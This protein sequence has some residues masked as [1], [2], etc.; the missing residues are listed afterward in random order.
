MCGIM[1]YIGKEN[2]LP[3]IVDGLRRESY[4]GYDS[5]GVVVFDGGKTHYVKAVGKLEKLEEKLAGMQITGTVGLGHNRWATHGEVTELNAHPHTDCKQNIFVVH[6]GIIENY[7]VLKEALQ[8]KGHVFVSQ[9]DT[10]VLAHLIEEY[11]KGD[12]KQAVAEALLQVKGA[13]AIAVIAKQDPEKIVVARLSSPLVIAK[14]DSGV[15]VASDPA[16]IVSH[17]KNMVFLDDGEIAVIT[18]DSFLVTDAKNVAHEKTAT[19][20]AWN[21]EEIQKAGFAHFMQKEIMQQPQT[22]AQSLAGRVLVDEG[23]AKLGGLEELKNAVKNIS[24][25]R[26]IGCGSAFFAI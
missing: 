16:A 25:I 2:A 24:Q 14:T 8:A 10:E 18:K 1:G 23:E 22:L 5:S 6:N 15:F 17:T 21:M 7:Q 4:R 20:L 3:F 11:F 19:Q 9:T 12:L 13:Y 26:L